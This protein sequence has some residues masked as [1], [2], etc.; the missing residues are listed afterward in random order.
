[1]VQEQY[2]TLVSLLF[3]A[4][5]TPFKKDS[6]YFNIF[7]AVY[8]KGKELYD[9]NDTDN[10]SA[11]CNNYLNYLSAVHDSSTGIKTFETKTPHGAYDG[12]GVDPLEYMLRFNQ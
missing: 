9:T 10:L 6:M 1:M 2:D 8:K 11:L 3:D 4:N 7:Q 5:L 12:A